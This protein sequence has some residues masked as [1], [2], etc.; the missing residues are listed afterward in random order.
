M[1]QG[2]SIGF[3]RLKTFGQFCGELLLLSEGDLGGY[4]E[5]FGCDVEHID[6]FAPRRPLATKFAV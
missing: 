3:P 2:L 6:P 5:V 4:V 1:D